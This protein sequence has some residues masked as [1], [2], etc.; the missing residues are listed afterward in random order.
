MADVTA[1][2]ALLSQQSSLLL[3][4]E[5]RR[6]PAMVEVVL[7]RLADTVSDWE[8]KGVMLDPVQFEI[9]T[10]ILIKQFAAS[11]LAMQSIVARCTCGARLADPTQGSNDEADGQD[12]A[13]G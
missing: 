2:V 6:N 7:D 11:H 9:I 4:Q 8:G 10:D 3:L 1:V 5:S 12:V 13:S